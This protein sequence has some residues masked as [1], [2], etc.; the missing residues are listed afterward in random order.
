MGRAIVAISG[1]AIAPLM[2]LT[3][4]FARITDYLRRLSN[5]LT[6]DYRPEQHYMRGPG[7]AWRKKHGQKPAA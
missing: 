4:P 7:P 5:A 3:R 6:D 2:P 1:A